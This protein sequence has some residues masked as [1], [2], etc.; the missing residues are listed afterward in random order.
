MK[1]ICIKEITPL[2]IGK[3]YIVHHTHSSLEFDVIYNLIEYERYGYF[4]EEYILPIS[5]YR[6]MQLEKISKC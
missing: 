3:I 2:K 1:V 5:K 6:K 4:S